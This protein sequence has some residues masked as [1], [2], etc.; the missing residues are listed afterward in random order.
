MPSLYSSWEYHNGCT[1]IE[2][3]M[4]LNGEEL[5]FLY[6]KNKMNGKCQHRGKRQDKYLKH[7]N[8]EKIQHFAGS[9]CQTL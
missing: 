3:Y 4:E 5:I 1:Q 2:K 7:P 8:V 6:L 9:H